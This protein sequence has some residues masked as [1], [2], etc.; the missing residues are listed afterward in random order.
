M[1]TKNTIDSIKNIV[2]KYI[3]PKDYKMFIFG[4]QAT[5]KNIQ[6]SDIDIGVDGKNPLM[7]STIVKLQEEF[8]NS[9]IPNTIDIIDFHTVSDRF[10]KVSK[11]HIIPL[12]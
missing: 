9:D 4:S 8:E 10:K 1:I 5:G 3:D 7:G 12:S 6:S 11:Q 2:F